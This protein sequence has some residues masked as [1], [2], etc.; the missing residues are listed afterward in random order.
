MAGLVPFN[1]KND[2]MRAGA[3]DGF[4]RMLDDFFSDAWPFRRNLMADTFKIDVEDCE[5]H[6]EVEAELPGIEKGDVDL[7]IDQGRLTIRVAQSQEKEDKKKNYIHKERRYSAMSR[8]IYL[9]DA[10][11]D[12]IKAKLDNGVLCVQVPK[13]KTDRQGSSIEIE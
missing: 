7:S 3:F 1:R 12:G 4:D 9:A 8:S 2:G 13:Q 10:I 6:Y 11:P 5:D